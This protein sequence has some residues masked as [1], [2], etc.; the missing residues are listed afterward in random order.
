MAAT[1]EIERTEKITVNVG[2]VDLGEIDLLVREGFYA[3]RTEFIRGAI[4]AQL[5]TRATAVEQTVARKTLAL[6]TR[7]YTRRELEELRAA[8]K[9]ID[10]RVLGLASIANDVPA[11][12]ARAT[13]AS[14]E[15]LGAFRASE[16]VKAALADRIV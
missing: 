11:D 14:V 3:N 15:V 1:G 2:V 5:A 10:V 9:R 6:G 7:H 16:A 12:L 13:I 8:G 4:R